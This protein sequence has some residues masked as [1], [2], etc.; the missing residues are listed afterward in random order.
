M[1][2]ISAFIILL[3]A[4]FGGMVLALSQQNAPAAFLPKGQLVLDLTEIS[5]EA[6]AAYEK[7][8]ALYASSGFIQ[9]F[10][11]EQQQQSHEQQQLIAQLVAQSLAQTELSKELYEEQLLAKLGVAVDSYSSHS[12]EILLFNITQQNYRSYLV[13]IKLFDPDMIK[14][15]L[16]H[17]ELGRIE[18]T[19]AAV[20]KEDAIFG[21]N[22]GGFFYAGQNNYLPMGNTMVDGK[23]INAFAPA[24]GDVFFTGFSASGALIGGL[25]TEEQQLMA[26]NPVAGVSF[27]PILLQGRLPVDIPGRWQGTRHPRTII[28]NFG[29]GDIFFWVI[30]GRRPGWSRGATLEEAQIKLLE[31]GVVDAYNLDGGGSSTMVFNGKLIN[32]PSD[33]NE[34]AVAT[35]IIIVP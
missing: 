25:F 9:S 18:T 19:S 32:R 31:L 10:L 33:G 17:G 28:G 29:N 34:R 6:Q 35:T 22:G 12:V 16:G 14:V 26:L 4:P 23:L 1:K 11:E 5:R 27:S 20:R 2:L 13:K 24:T 30:D 15:R 3:L 21:V 8:L 7:T